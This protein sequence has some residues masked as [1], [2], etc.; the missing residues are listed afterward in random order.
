MSEKDFGPSLKKFEKRLF[1]CSQCVNKWRSVSYKGRKHTAE[2][3][4]KMRGRK[5]SKETVIKQNIAKQRE[6]IRVEGI[7]ECD[8]CNKA[9]NSNTSLRAHK[10]YCGLEKICCTCEY[11]DKKFT[12]ERGMR[13][14]ITSI[15]NTPARE[16]QQM[17]QKMRNKKLLSVTRTSSKEEEMFFESIS[18]IFKDVI[19]SYQISGYSHVYDIY[20]P[21][22]NLIIEFDGDFWHGNSKLFELSK[23]MKQQ[24]CI[25]RAHSKHAKE[26][27]YNI[28]RVWASESK[29]YL[30][31][32]ANEQYKNYES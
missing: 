13:I 10:S 24:F 14:H 32:I 6:N 30:E 2:A 15:H 8:R 3:L 29:E 31:R 20:I 25:D 9:F 27:G 7:F 11:C 21:S 17:R 23:R 22:K 28:A 19:R 4:K 26:K 12:S 16:R 1:C 5:L 18:L